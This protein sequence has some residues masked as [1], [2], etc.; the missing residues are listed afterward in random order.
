MSWKP[1]FNPTADTWKTL[2]VIVAGMVG[3]KFYFKSDV[4]LYVAGGIGAVSFLFP[5]LGSLLVWLWVKLG[6]ALGWFTPKIILGAVF[7]LMLL[8]IALL[9]KVFGRDKLL[10]RRQKGSAFAV[11][12]HQY[13]KEDLGK[14]W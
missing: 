3:L 8:P 5:A 4:F 1:N 2:M 7:F 12:D 10:L 6:E 14:A 9:A 11:R 13:T